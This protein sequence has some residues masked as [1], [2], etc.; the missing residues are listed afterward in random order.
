MI[1]IL[2]L[3]TFAG[4]GIA[5]GVNGPVLVPQQGHVGPM[6][7][8]AWSSNG[9]HIVTAGGDNSI[10]LWETK[11]GRVLARTMAFPDMHG[12][13]EKVSFSR[14]GRYLLATINSSNHSRPITL[15]WDAQTREEVARFNRLAS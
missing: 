9:N 13:I 7:A 3:F 14:S 8:A 5:Q 2:I 4:S 1:S 10:I 6:T 15:L 11:T 12:L